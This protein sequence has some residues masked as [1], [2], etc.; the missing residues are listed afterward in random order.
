MEV[1][2]TPTQLALGLSLANLVLS[3]KILATSVDRGEMTM[4]DVA[5]LL[6]SV[7]EGLEAMADQLPQEPKVMEIAT[8]SIALCERLMRMLSAGPH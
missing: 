6:E 3:A 7:R 5:D 4:A 1:T 8:N 2:G